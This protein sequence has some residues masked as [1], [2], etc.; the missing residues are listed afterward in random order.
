MF[1]FLNAKMPR[2]RPEFTI[3]YPL[4][5]S[6]CE[7]PRVAPTLLVLDRHDDLLLHTYRVQECQVRNRVGWRCLRI[8]LMVLSRDSS[9]SVQHTAPTAKAFLNQNRRNI[10]PYLLST[11]P[12]TQSKPRIA[13]SGFHVR[14]PHISKF[15]IVDGYAIRTPF[16]KGHS[17]SLLG[18]WSPKLPLSLHLASS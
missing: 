17:H 9:R 13:W 11:M 10:Q 4:Q 18:Y 6:R 14:I 3:V 2:R 5:S 7:Q 1:V 8:P 16:P 15:T 12:I